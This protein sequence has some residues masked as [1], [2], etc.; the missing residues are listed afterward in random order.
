MLHMK[1]FSKEQLTNWLIDCGYQPEIVPHERVEYLLRIKRGSLPLVVAR[2]TKAQ[3]LSIE[4]VIQLI[5]EDEGLYTPQVDDQLKK[6]IVQEYLG[7]KT[8]VNFMKGS[9]IRVYDRIYDDGFTYDRFFT[10]IRNV[11]YN[12]LH[13]L[14]LLRTTVGTNT[15]V[16]DSLN[17]NYYT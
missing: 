15:R 14:D 5:P 12:A 17:P 2:P 6:L 7:L 8:D 16:E 11:T 13:L 1:S 4:A 9:A 10:S 3:Y